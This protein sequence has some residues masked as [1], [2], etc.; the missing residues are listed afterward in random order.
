[1][2]P[3]DLDTSASQ[4]RRAMEDLQRAWHVV[5]ESW[6]DRVSRQFGEQY[7]DPL[8]PATKQT[9]DAASRMRELLSRM[10]TEC[11]S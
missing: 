3:W 6:D 7:L 5:N 4:L 8:V 11:G 10:D 2:R 9:L 1:M